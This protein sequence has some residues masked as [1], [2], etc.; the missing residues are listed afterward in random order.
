VRIGS[1]PKLVMV[2]D[3]WLMM[4]GMNKA[5]AYKGAAH[6]AYINTIEKVLSIKELEKDKSLTYS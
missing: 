4:V 6:P 3:T 5:N 2:A 1:G